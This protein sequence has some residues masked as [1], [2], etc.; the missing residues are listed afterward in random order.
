MWFWQPTGAATNVAMTNALTAHSVG[1]T[2]TGALTGTG[3]IKSTAGDVTLNAL[4]IGTAD[5]DR[6]A[7]SVTG[8]NLI[9]TTTGTAAHEGD[10]F[11]TSADALSLGAITTDNTNAQSVDIKTTGAGATLTNGVANTATI[12][13]N[14]DVVLA[15]TGAA[16]NVA[17]TNALTAHSVGITATGALTGTGII[18]ST[19]GDVTLNALEI[20]T[21]DGDRRARKRDGRQ[22]DSYDDRYRGA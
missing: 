9:L 14:T 12:G 8:G 10:A 20:G 6:R 17:M 15:T 16:T 7:V 5:G 22:S 13:T 21:A 1:I 4:E 3:I 18:K 19:A 11:I 2:A